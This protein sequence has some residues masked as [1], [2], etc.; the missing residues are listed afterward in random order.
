MR[1]SRSTESRIVA[2]LNEGEAGGPIT[3]ILRQ[4]NV[5][6]AAYFQW[7]STYAGASVDEL[8]RLKELEADGKVSQFQLAAPGS[9][10]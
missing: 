5:S 3:E 8:K 2:I 7:R 10:L 4:H 1:K 9:G 6:K